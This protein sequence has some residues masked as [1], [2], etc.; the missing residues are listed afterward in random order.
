MAE[1]KK[2]SFGFNTEDQRLL[3]ALKKKLE[4]THGTLSNIAIIRIALRAA[5]AA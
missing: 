2:L 1:L 4:P 5:K 3:A